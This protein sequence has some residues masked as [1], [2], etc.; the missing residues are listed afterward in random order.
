[1]ADVY[2]RITPK[3]GVCLATLGPGAT[4]LTTGIA[5][6]NMDRSRV[7][8]ITGQTDSH[9]L[10]KESHQ[11]MDAITMLKPITKWNWSIRNVDNIP[12]IVRRAF[13]ISLEEKAGATHIELPQDVTKRES[14]ILPVTPTPTIRS[15]PHPSIV[16]KAAKLIIDA[17]QPI[18]L[19]GNGC[20]RENASSH[21]RRFVEETGFCSMG[22]SVPGAIASQ[23]VY[24]DRK[25]V[26]MCGDGSFL[27][28]VQ[29]IETAVRLKLPLIIVVWCDGG[30]GLISLKEMDEYGREAFTK[31]NNPDFV[32][33]AQSFGA[34]GYHVRSSEDF[35]KVFEE[36]KKSTDTPVI[37][38]IDVDYSRNKLLLH[39]DFEN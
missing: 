24:P 15:K 10:H 36:S 27:M 6:A 2:G 1:M 14:S 37:I 8:A 31:F 4:N 28:N 39:D 38:A 22:F 32:K 30:Y 16:Q 23:L 33:L 21:I 35:S 34:I 7:L 5:N 12:E 18:I 26:A 3:V 19:V 11:N 25:V 29:E 20:V 9:L 17:K 13:K